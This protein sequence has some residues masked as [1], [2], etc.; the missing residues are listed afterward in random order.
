M[1]LFRSLL[2]GLGG[3]ETRLDSAGTAEETAAEERQRETAPPITDQQVEESETG[4]D[5]SGLSPESADP[6]TAALQRVRQLQEARDIEGLVNGLSDEWMGVDAQGALRDIGAP[7]IPLLV[8]A[9]R[10]EKSSYLREVIVRIL[11][12]IEDVEAVEPLI[13]TLRDEDDQVRF[14][15]VVALESFGDPRAIEPLAVALG[16]DVPKVRLAAVTALGRISDPRVV[17][18][19]ITA[20]S[21]DLHHNVRSLAAEMLGS[22]GDERA[23]EPLKTALNDGDEWVRGV[24]KEAL[25]K[26]M[27]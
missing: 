4:P 2:R 27:G 3:K 5:P 17:E 13:E 23:I 8:T 12:R 24:A 1:G 26:L 14:A 22:I 11:G 10:I 15:T 7:A 20:L 18:P 9:L 21:V 16:H 25:R 19:L 6:Y